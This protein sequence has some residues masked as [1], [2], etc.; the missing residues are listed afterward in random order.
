MTSFNRALNATPREAVQSAEGLVRVVTYLDG[1]R[2][3]A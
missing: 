2:A 1:A 3:L